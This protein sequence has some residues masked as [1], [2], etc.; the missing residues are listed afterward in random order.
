MVDIAP[1]VDST[2]FSIFTLHVSPI[3]S[4]LLGALG[5]LLSISLSRILFRTRPFRRIP[6]AGLVIIFG[7]LLGGIFI[8]THV[9]DAAILN[10][11]ASFFFVST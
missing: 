4:S 5:L 6:E 9:Q 3:A 1:D 2:G 10:I 11:S 8:A 7:M